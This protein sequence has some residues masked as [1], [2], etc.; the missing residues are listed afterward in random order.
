[1]LKRN[2]KGAGKKKLILDF[3]LAD[4]I[5]WYGIRFAET[6]NFPFIVGFRYIASIFTDFTIFRNN[7]SLK[8]LCTEQN[9]SC[10]RER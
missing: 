5:V 7:I 9:Y 1:M 4:L 10:K 3:V 6:E 8:N 2:R